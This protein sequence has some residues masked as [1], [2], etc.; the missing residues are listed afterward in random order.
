[1]SHIIFALLQQK[2]PLFAVLAVAVLLCSQNAITVKQGSFSSSNFVPFT[3]ESNP[4]LISRSLSFLEVALIDQS[5][6]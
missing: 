1:M 3:G 2:G 4:A 5:G 6:P